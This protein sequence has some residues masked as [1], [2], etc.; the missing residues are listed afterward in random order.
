MVPTGVVRVQLVDAQGKPLR[1]ARQGEAYV[2]IQD[3]DR[4]GIGTWGGGGQVD[5]NGVCEFKSVPPGR[6]R[7]SRKP[8]LEKGQAPDVNEIILTVKP[9]Q[10]SE[11]R[12][13][14]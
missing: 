7:L 2:H 1:F 13:T 4:T 3:A 10:I 9:R 6:Y 11:A 12:L 8:L 5:T 14:Q